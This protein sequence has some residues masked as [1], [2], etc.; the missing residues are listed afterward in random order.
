M[1][2]GSNWRGQTKWEQRG[3]A[4]H[5]EIASD[6][7]FYL[8]V[9]DMFVPP[10]G[11]VQQTLNITELM[12]TLGLSCFKIFSG[13][14]DKACFSMSTQPPICCE[15]TSAREVGGSDK[16]FSWTQSLQPPVAACRSCSSQGS[17]HL[18]RQGRTSKWC[19]WPGPTAELKCARVLKTMLRYSTA[20]ESVPQ[21][22]PGPTFS[23]IWFAAICGKNLVNLDENIFAP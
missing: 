5:E 14:V 18:L 15:G 22:P 3:A 21:D 9:V 16:P 23:W 19:K 4:C 10:C 2:L 8:L 1:A 13:T 17:F 11:C 6:P 7:T 20:T 12:Q